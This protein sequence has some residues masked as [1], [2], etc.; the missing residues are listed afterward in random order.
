MPSS[1]RS[2]RRS[3]GAALRLLALDSDGTVLDSMTRKHLEAFMPAFIRH[4]APAC[5]GAASAVWRFVNLES[6]NRGCN[7]YRALVQCLRLL[8]GHP[9][10]QKADPAWHRTA[11]FLEAWLSSEP[12]P[13]KSSLKRAVSTSYAALAPVLSWT[14]DVDSAIAFLEPSRAFAGALAAIPAIAMSGE[15][16]VLSAAP[17]AM[18]RLEWKA[19]GI[20]GFAGDIDG[21][22]RGPKVSCLASRA[23][24]R[25]GAVL[26]V[27]DS[28]GDLEVARSSG[29]AFF[30][31]IAGRE[32]ECWSLFIES[33]FP[34]FLEG[35]RS[36]GRG[37]L[38]TFLAA[39]PL[40]PPWLKE[41]TP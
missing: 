25:S 27:G 33:G 18:V 13:S 1:S 23:A 34:R 29:A 10:V 3:R 24:G 21:Q 5:P 16:L 4:F 14:E 32:E 8:P 39:F 7:R 17:E 20:L 31:I 28:P 15:L 38:C 9:L 22:E 19:A 30:P 40:D 37:L 35:E 26:V 2:K 36:P 41:R 12:G 11:A 6:R